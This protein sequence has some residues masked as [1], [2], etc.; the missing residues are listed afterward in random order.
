MRKDGVAIITLSDQIQFYYDLV[1]CSRY[2]LMKTQTRSL[3]IHSSKGIVLILQARRGCGMS[4]KQNRPNGTPRDRI[5]LR[6]DGSR[7]DGKG[8]WNGTER[9]GRN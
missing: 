3:I 9:N 8:A 7:E 2:M 4:D 1:T 5:Q 6:R